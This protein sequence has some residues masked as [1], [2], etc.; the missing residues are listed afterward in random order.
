M[1][2]TYRKNAVLQTYGKRQKAKEE[3]HFNPI[4]SNFL[5][6]CTGV[7]ASANLDPL[8]TVMRKSNSHK[9][10]LHTFSVRFLKKRFTIT[11][12]ERN[13]SWDP[14]TTVTSPHMKPNR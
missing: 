6:D 13:P 9:S 14:A 4:V 10:G 12:T 1:T 8:F 5:H 3:A 2:E 11:Y 7:S